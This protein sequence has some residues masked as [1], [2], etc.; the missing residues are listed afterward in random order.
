MYAISRPDG[1]KL[2]TVRVVQRSELS[3]QPGQVLLQQIIDSRQKVHCLCCGDYEAPMLVIRNTAGFLGLYPVHFKGKGRRHSHGCAHVTGEKIAE[4]F[5]VFPVAISSLSGN[6]CVDFDFLFRSPESSGTCGHWQGG[7]HDLSQALRSLLW[8]LFVRSGMN[9]A[10]PRPF[11]ANPWLE[12]LCSAREIS[13]RGVA[14]LT[15]LA[16][17]LLL[18]T[19]ADPLTGISNYARLCDSEHGCGRVLTACLLPRCSEDGADLGT[20]S[21]DDVFGVTVELHHNVLT[22]A[23]EKSPFAREWNEANGQVL[24][25]G[26]ANTEVYRPPNGDSPRKIAKLSQLVLMPVTETLNPLP[27]RR[28]STAF[29]Q[30]MAANKLFMVQ[31]NEDPLI[32]MRSGNRTF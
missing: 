29:T 30:K 24:A 15:S 8:L 31:P 17:L 6:L 27:T 3:G 16:H 26:L 14:H 2:L 21:F 32:A 1:E 11:K 28:H 22:Q 9:I 12:M 4:A 7:H 23:L 5:G 19:T 20:V 13:V 25:F 10:V 18:P